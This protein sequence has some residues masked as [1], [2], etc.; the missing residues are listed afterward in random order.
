MLKW[1]PVLNVSVRKET[2]NTNILQLSSQTIPS[3]VHISLDHCHWQRQLSQRTHSDSD[4]YE[5]GCKMMEH[6]EKGENAA[7]AQNQRFWIQQLRLDL[8]ID[9]CRFA[10]PLDLRG[11]RRVLGSAIFHCVQRPRCAF[12]SPLSGKPQWPQRHGA[13][14][15]H[16]STS[17]TQPGASDPRIYA[18]VWFWW[19]QRL[20]KCFLRAHLQK[21]GLTIICSVVYG[22][23]VHLR[24]GLE[25]S[26]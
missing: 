19:S 15:S 6:C 10:A 26:G 13:V 20:I 2:T 5:L 11:R 18:E 3:F 22:W 4:L 14:S 23:S 25:V 9:P 24:T 12:A 1:L 8:G 7:K 21:Y 16:S 17:H